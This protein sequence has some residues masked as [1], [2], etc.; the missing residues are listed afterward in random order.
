MMHKYMNHGVFT[1]RVYSEQV[2]KLIKR[3]MGDRVILLQQSPEHS[4]L[5]KKRW[6]IKSIPHDPT[7]DENTFSFGILL[8]VEKSFVCCC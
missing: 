5:S 7:N 8:H 4:S 6:N 3:A 1:Q 2:L